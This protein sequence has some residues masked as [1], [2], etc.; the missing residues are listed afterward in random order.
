[1]ISATGFTYLGLLIFVAIVSIVAAAAAALGSIA[2]RR[3]AE[4]ELL[5]VGAQFR[6][7][8]K[9]Y[10]EATPPG[11]DPYPLSL[12]ALLKD[13]RFPTVVRHLRQIYIDP[14]TG[15][16]DWL[17]VTTPNG[18][19]MGISSA[20]DRRPIKVDRFPQPFEAFAG[21]KSYSEWVFYYRML[22]IAVAHPYD[23]STVKQNATDLR[24]PANADTVP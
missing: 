11:S 2:Q 14:L 4:E 20:S 6:A 23:V 24:I 9:S 15:K 16:S 10:Y 3:I 22:P 18:E 17:L 21:K 5:F 8:L 13:T 19:I 1:M 7:A 12:Q